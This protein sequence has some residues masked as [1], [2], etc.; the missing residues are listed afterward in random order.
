MNEKNKFIVDLNSLI[1]QFLSQK[2]IDEYSSTIMNTLHPKL[3]SDCSSDELFDYYFKESILTEKVRLLTDTLITFVEKKLTLKKYI[4]FLLPFG[5]LLLTQ[6]EHEIANDI[7]NIILKISTVEKGMENQKGE[8]LLLVAEF[9]IKQADWKVAVTNIKKARDIFEVT[10]NK[11]GLA[12]CEFLIGSMYVEKGDLKAGSI[13][14]NNC[15]KYSGDSRN[16]L[17]SG[18]VE[19][20]LGII[21]YIEGNMTKALEF[22]EK[23][24]TKFKKLGDTRRE[25][26]VMQNIGMIFRNNKDYSSAL[27]IYSDCLEISKQ[28]GYQPITNLCY[29]NIAEIQLEKG[30]ITKAFNFAQKS[31]VLSYQLNDKLTLA[32]IHK[33]LG[34]LS[35]RERNYASAENFLLT[36]LRLNNDLNQ[37]LNCAETNFQLGLLYKEKGNKKDA[38]NHLMNAFKYYH[39]NH[40]KPLLAEI[41]SHLS[42][43]NN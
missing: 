23:A 34:V 13:R 42:S 8:A 36:S 20:N 9:R 29:L 27:K 22:Y 2:D 28:F 30:D 4:E 19:V 12:L 32:D 39:K 25:A 37:E 33:M 1:K 18:M 5:K 6:G 43:L 40:S 17:L 24:L 11:D 38:Y 31:L 26:E 14:L 16:P 3:S 41:E 35:L 7:A 15:M 21:S 10:N